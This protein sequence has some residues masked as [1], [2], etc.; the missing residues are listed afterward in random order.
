MLELMRSHYRGVEFSLDPKSDREWM[1]GADP[2]REGTMSL[3][4]DL[5]GSRTDAMKACF[6]AIDDILDAPLA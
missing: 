2:K 1:W 3:R 5:V 4:G 6:R